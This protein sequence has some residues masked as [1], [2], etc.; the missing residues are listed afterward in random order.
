MSKVEVHIQSVEL[1]FGTT[2]FLSF[3]RLRD[4]YGEEGVVLL[5][6]LSGPLR[7]TRESLIAYGPVLTLSLT[8][9][10]LRMTGRDDVVR[11]AADRVLESRAA[12]RDGDAF[13]LHS[14]GDLWRVLRTLSGAF[15]CA[16]ASQN[17]FRCGFIGYLGY[18]VVR[19]VERL[20]YRIPSDGHQPTVV[21]SMFEGLVTFDLMR[22]RT[23]VLASRAEGLWSPRPPEAIGRL[24]TEVSP[25]RE[26]SLDGLPDV[27][28]PT[29]VRQSMRRADYVEKVAKAFHYISIGDIYQVQLGHEI[30]VTTT[31]TPLDVYRR[32]R[33]RNPSPYM[34]LMPSGEL[35]LIGASPES[36]LRIEDGKIIIRPIAGTARRGKTPDE[37]AEI[38][39]RLRTDEKELAEHLMLV[40]LCRNDIGRVCKAGTLEASE[41]FQVEQYSQ[42]NHL[43]SCIV[44]DLRDDVDAFDA[45]AATFPAGT[46]TGAPKIRAMEII[47]ELETTRRGPYAG[48]VG[49]IDFGGYVNMAL[50]I[51]STVRRDGR[52]LLRA[53]AGSVADSVA[54][55]EW[56]E[57][58]HKMGITYWAVAGE[59]LKYE[60]LSD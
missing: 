34:Y 57:T 18:D 44:G 35:T 8:D 32:L 23:V 13:R 40:D 56:R 9:L 26:Q 49:L 37:D 6:S 25:S 14:E 1:P 33:G 22:N 47:E 38:V 24:L 4:V 20:P 29:G 17:S 55:N 59:E 43:V 3:L 42:V 28:V 54:E 39:E 30:E 11:F 41:L 27:P 53:S 58:L 31:A 10:V 7:E 21:L 50:C 52:Y 51:R 16:T 5:E 12:D 36:F 48:A 15:H 60:G 46:M 2:P 45:I 19:S